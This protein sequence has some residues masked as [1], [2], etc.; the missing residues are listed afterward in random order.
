MLG[1]RC[2]LPLMSQWER[3]LLYMAFLKSALNCESQTVSINLH[4][5]YGSGSAYSDVCHTCGERILPVNMSLELNMPSPRLDCATMALPS[6][7]HSTTRLHV[8]ASH[9][10]SIVLLSHRSRCTN[11]EQFDLLTRLH[12]TRRMGWWGS[13]EG[14]WMT[15]EN[16]EPRPPFAFDERAGVKHLMK[17]PCR[18]DLMR[19]LHAVML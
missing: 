1:L 8:F 13:L 3:L 18:S 5:C 9:R 4:W 11:P 14:S 7:Q 10:R 15:A 16:F 12:P 19:V 2:V 6:L 17:T